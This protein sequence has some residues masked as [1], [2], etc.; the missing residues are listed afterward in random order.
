MKLPL[1]EDQIAL[2][3]ATRAFARDEIAPNARAWEKAGTIPRGFLAR[4]AGMGL[5]GLCVP[6]AQGGT[7]LS[8]TDAALVFAALAES[9]PSVAAFLSIHNMCATM[10]AGHATDAVRKAWLPRLITFDAVAAYCLT[11]PGAGSDAAALSTR[12]EPVAAGWALTG[13]KAF[14]SGGGYADLYLVMARS[15]G[16]G[17]TGISAFAVPTGSAGLSFGPPE[18]KLGWRAHPTAAVRLDAC[19]VPADHLLGGEGGGFALA[20]QGLDGGRLNIAACSLGGATQALRV[21]RGHMAQRVAF[22]RRLDQFQALQFRLAD[23][24]TSLSA[25]WALVLQ[26][27]AALDGGQADATVQIAMAKRLATDTGFAV[28]NDALQMLGGYGYLADFGLEKILR[29]LR[30]HQIVE[31]T[32]EVMRLI[33]ARAMLAEE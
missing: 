11:E 10:L 26:A 24:Q 21:A 23:M 30:A 18:D 12:A 27:A 31:G 17:A 29:D 13:S 4:A 6:T 2:T 1:T 7:G 3:D 8:R 9:C 14:I 5:G 15:G 32:N 33:V 19:A 16:A 28:A 22:G 20:M 25:A